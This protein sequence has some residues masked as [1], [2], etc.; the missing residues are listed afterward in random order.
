MTD[1]P[2]S[3]DPAEVEKEYTSLLRV[4]GSREDIVCSGSYFICDNRT[5]D[6]DFFIPNKHI[7]LQGL[8]MIGYSPNTDDP[9]YAESDFVSYRKGYFNVITVNDE[10]ALD[11]IRRATE[12]CQRLFLT[13]KED[14]IFVFEKFR[15]P[16]RIKDGEDTPRRTTTTV[17]GSTAYPLGTVQPLWL[18]TEAHP[19][20]VSDPWGLQL[21]SP[22]RRVRGDYTPV[23]GARY[24]PSLRSLTGS[25]SSTTSSSTA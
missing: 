3:I 7:I 9:N 23:D 6:V 14:R 22:S 15:C 20:D 2:V 16:S 17:P 21:T 24:Y 10:K 4:V 18:D 1:K 5:T 13:D 25:P 11:N 19:N 8:R 12:V